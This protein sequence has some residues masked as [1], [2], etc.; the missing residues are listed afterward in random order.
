MITTIGERLV[1][2]GVAHILPRSKEEVKKT[3]RE[4]EPKVVGVEL[5]PNR[6]FQLMAKENSNQGEESQFTQAGIL[7]KILQYLQ[8]RMGKKTG[9]FPGEEMVAAIQS[10]EESGAEVKLIDQSIDRTIQRLLDKMSLWEKIKIFGGVMLSF[11]WSRDEVELE[12]LTRE[13][14]VKELIEILR[15]TSE[16][17]YQVLIEER[18]QYMAD[19]ITEILSSRSGKV[20]CVV[21]AGHIP[22]L[23]D[24][25]ESRLGEE[26]LQPWETF[27]MEW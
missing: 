23:S 16:T 6:Y 13:E 15:D 11:I 27:Q 4:E 12:E 5:C 19:Q 25:L 3:I 17:A 8:E 24:E 22:G 14:A 20:V 21:G 2:V 10:S 7:T 9:M 1:L 26:D 18:N